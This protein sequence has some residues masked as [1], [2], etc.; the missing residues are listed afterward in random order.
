[1]KRGLTI[2]ELID[3][4]EQQP[5]KYRP[6]YDGDGNPINCVSDVVLGIQYLDVRPLKEGL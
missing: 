3:L 6:V 1:M 2:K 4:L 5:N